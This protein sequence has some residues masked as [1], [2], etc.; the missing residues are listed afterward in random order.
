MYDMF[1][2]EVNINTDYMS[3]N[4][5][6]ITL[7]HELCHAKGYASE[8]DCN[9]IA[10]LACCSSARADFRYAGYYEIFWNLYAVTE[11]IAKATGET[12]PEF[13]SASDMNPVIRDMSASVIYWRQIDKEVDTIK[14]RLGIDIKE[15][16]N[17]VNDTFLKSNGETGL[18]SYNVPDSIY[19]RYYLT[20]IGAADV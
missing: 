4:E 3:I 9:T 1:L 15:T 18:E 19:V 8:T 5:Y 14:E 10:T 2:A 20:Y 17:V 7:C 11:K 16:S 13:V 12:V 6:P